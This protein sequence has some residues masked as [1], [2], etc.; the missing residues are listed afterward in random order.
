MFIFAITCENVHWTSEIRS[1]LIWVGRGE[2]ALAK[3][4]P[5]GCSGGAGWDL[6]SPQQ[7]GCHRVVEILPTDQT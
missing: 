3:S 4:P 5:G 2:L 7:C 1:T 6:V